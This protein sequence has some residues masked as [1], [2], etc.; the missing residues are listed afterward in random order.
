MV[1]LHIFFIHILT[2]V[3]DAVLGQATGVNV[4]LRRQVALRCDGQPFAKGRVD[5]LSALMAL[6]FGDECQDGLAPLSV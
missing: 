2:N 5:H 1:Y 3:I 4:Q 6:R